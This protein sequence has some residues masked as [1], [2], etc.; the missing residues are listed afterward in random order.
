MKR[1]DNNRILT[2]SCTHAPYQHPDAIDFLKG[3]K[4]S[5]DP[6]RVVHLGDETD[7]HALSFYKSDPDLYSAGHELKAACKFLKS[8]ETLFPDMIV[9]TS[10]HGTMVHRK[11]I[12][13]GIP[14]AFVRDLKD[15][16]DVGWKWTLDLQIRHEG[17][18]EQIYFTHHKAKDALTLAQRMGMNVVQ[19]HWHSKF[20][21]DYSSN[22]NNLL[23]GMQVG[24]LTDDSSLAFANNKQDHYRPIVGCGMIIDGEPRLVPMLLKKNGRWNGRIIL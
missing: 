3:V 9:V 23:W 5:Y 11:A 24:C 19:G 15:V 1:Y 13:A 10:N 7:N 6:D 17:S 18:R 22:P 21:I 14:K 20:N 12:D 2:M 4:D 8:L 16:Y